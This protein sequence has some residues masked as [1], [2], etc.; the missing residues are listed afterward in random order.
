MLSI[1]VKADV[2]EVTRYLSKVERKQL[3]FA[4]ALALTRTAQD[5]QKAVKA[6]LPRKL[7]RPKPFTISGVAVLRADKLALVSTVYFKPTTAEYLK[8]V[9][10]GGTKR[11]R[12]RG[13][14]VPYKKNMKLNVY[15]GIKNKRKKAA[16]WRAGKG[17]TKTEFVATIKGIHGIW[18]RTGGKRNP[19]VKLM[20]WFEPTVTYERN[21]FPF[22]KMV[23]GVARARFKR[24]FDSALNVALATGR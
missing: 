13:V 23:E 12:G 15:G 10:E 11:G 14:I 7:D 24:N 4:T 9:L 20:A 16:L 8:Y 19:G 3:P 17:T 5:A 2:A 21:K 1:S 22:H 6:Q 18:R